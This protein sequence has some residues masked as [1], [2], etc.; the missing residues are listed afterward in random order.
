MS[1][2]AIELLLGGG[3][4]VGAWV[5]WRYAVWWYMSN[6]YGTGKTRGKAVH[7]WMKFPRV[8]G[9]AS[10]TVFSIL[11]LTAGITNGGH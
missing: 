3:L 5:H 8:V 4:A 2:Q 11:L 9:T 1:N 10:M 6:R 7:P